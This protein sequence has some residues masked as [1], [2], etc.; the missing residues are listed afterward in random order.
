MKPN[1]PIIA[2]SEIAELHAWLEHNHAS[3]EGI[4]V[5]VYN[6]SSGVQSVSFEDILEE[7]LCFGWSESVRLK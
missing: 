6:K 4:F 2:F 7:G 3:S 1:L 5:R